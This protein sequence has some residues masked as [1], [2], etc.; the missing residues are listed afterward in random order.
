MIEASVEPETAQ[1]NQDRP[2]VHSSNADL[3]GALERRESVGK[4]HEDDGDGN[5]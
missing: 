3:F 5:R 4:S 1:S 2:D